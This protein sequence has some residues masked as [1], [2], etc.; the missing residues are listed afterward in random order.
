MARQTDRVVT[1]FTTYEPAT[2]MEPAGSPL[3]VGSLAEGWR[4][5]TVAED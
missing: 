3:G 5:K 4:T 1:W 2:I